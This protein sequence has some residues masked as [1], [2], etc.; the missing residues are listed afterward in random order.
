MLIV[1]ERARSALFT[2]DLNSL[3]Y[4]CLTIKSDVY[5]VFVNLEKSFREYTFYA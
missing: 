1:N 3:T 5:E 4:T 2:N